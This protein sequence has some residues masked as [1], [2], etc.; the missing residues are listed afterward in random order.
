MTVWL[1]QRAKVNSPANEEFW[2]ERMEPAAHRLRHQSQARN[3]FWAFPHE[4][5]IAEPELSPSLLI[6]GNATLSFELPDYNLKPLTGIDFSGFVITLLMN[7]PSRQFTYPMITT[8]WTTLVLKV[9]HFEWEDLKS[10]KLREVGSGPEP[11]HHAVA[12]TGEHKERC[13]CCIA[14][15]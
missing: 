3:G 4:R 12:I 1:T 10:A 14:R 11:A 5:T 8:L 15:H 13:C 6:L 7:N 9:Y 2:A